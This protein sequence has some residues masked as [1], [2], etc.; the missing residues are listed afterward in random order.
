MI[1][2]REVLAQSLSAVPPVR[3]ICWGLNEAKT[4]TQVNVSHTSLT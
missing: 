2:A 4:V 3:R 1:A